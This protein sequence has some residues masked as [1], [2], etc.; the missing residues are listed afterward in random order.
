[1]PVASQSA[2]SL[3]AIPVDVQVGIFCQLH[4]LT[5]VSSLATTCQTM[6]SVLRSNASTILRPVAKNCIV[7]YGGC[8]RAASA[9]SLNIL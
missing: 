8:L 7:G 2:P 4:D 5:D 3:L 9:T 6:L 1:M